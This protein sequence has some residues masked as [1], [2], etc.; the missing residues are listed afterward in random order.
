MKGVPITWSDLKER[1]NRCCWDMVESMA[2]IERWSHYREWSDLI[3]S[4]V[5]T[6]WSPWP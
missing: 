1:W 4:V 3:E 6:W 2:L 5:G